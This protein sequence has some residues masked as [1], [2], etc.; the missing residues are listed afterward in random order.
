MIRRE[1]GKRKGGTCEYKTKMMKVSKKNV[2]SKC[3][4]RNRREGKAE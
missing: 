2:G 3:D 1:G 4:Q